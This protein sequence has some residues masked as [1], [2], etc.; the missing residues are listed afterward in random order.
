MREKCES[1]KYA[2]IAK[3]TR[4][5]KVGGMVVVQN[6]GGVKCTREH[7]RNISF[8]NGEMKCSDYHERE[9]VQ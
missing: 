5:I 7:V 3:K 8:T 9:D 1:C 2:D 6:G 4:T